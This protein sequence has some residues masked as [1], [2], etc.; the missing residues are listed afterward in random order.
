MKN[1]ADWDREFRVWHFTVSYSQLLLRSINVANSDTRI[2]ILFSNVSM[3]HLTPSFDRLRVDRLELSDPI[4]SIYK[5]GIEGGEVSVFLL[6]GGEGY[7]YA[8]HCDWHEDLGGTRT[9]SKF[10]PLRGVE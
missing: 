10:G 3:L 2:D 6:N 8:T 5:A 4:P 1:I 9:P 7:V